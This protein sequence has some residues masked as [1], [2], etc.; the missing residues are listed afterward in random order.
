[1]YNNFTDPGF[2][3]GD[4]LRVPMDFVTDGV[5]LANYAESSVTPVLGKTLG[6][7]PSMRNGVEGL[8]LFGICPIIR[9]KAPGYRPGGPIGSC[10]KSIVSMFSEENVTFGQYLLACSCTY[11]WIPSRT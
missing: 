4:L 7:S 5:T 10:V 6:M 2:F 3:D 1:M 8:V 11:R 9:N